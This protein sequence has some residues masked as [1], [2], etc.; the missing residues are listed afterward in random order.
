MST[1]LESRARERQLKKK[2]NGRP[3]KANKKK[4][5]RDLEREMKN[6]GDTFL[7]EEHE[8]FEAAVTKSEMLAASNAR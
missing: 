4:D 3:A 1:N 6:K 2:V 8:N 5:K 7:L